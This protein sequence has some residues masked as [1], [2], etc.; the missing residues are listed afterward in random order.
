MLGNVKSEEISSNLGKINTDELLTRI[1]TNYKEKKSPAIL[2]LTCGTTALGS[3]DDVEKIKEKLVELEIPHYIHLDAAM[4]GGIPK[5][6]KNSPITN[7][8]ERMNE[9]DLDSISISLHKYIGNTRVNGITLA[10][11]HTNENYI[12][13]IGQRDVTFLGS[14]DFAAFSTLQ[15]IKELNN[16][17]NDMDYFNNIQKF[18]NLLLENGIDF[19]KGDSNGNTFVIDK[20]CDEICK[21]YQLSTFNFCEREC[22][23]IIIFPYHTIEDMQCLIYDIKSDKIKTKVKTQ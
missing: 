21:K 9:L 20:P 7:L 6:Q 16:R 11:A 4:Y 23:H 14:R 12:D 18:E 10:K 5:N 2:L 3:V 22:A 1:I 15:R 8:V 19:I 13:Y 17:S